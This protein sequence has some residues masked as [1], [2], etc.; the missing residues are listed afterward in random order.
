MGETE[1][2]FKNFK[3]RG[4]WVE[5]LF[6][7]RASREG[8][9]VSKP[10]GDSAAYDF[11]VESS[12]MCLRIQVKSTHARSSHGF[13]CCMRGSRRYKLDSF[14]FAAVYVIPVSAWFIVPRIGLPACMF[15]MPGR[16]GSKYNHYEEA[17]HLLKPP[18]KERTEQTDVALL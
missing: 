13:I 7:A 10:Y 3:Q 1:P 17:W 12:A 16:S 8:L 15:L 11:I 18:A 14:D 2:Q 4:E 9:Q 6:M 5:M